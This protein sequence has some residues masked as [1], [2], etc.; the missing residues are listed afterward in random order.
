MSK[1]QIAVN[2]VL[3]VLVAISVLVISAYCYYELTDKTYT[4][5]TNYL[6][7]QAPIDLYEKEGLSD[8]Q[9][10]EYEKRKL[11]TV[12]Y[13]SN[14]ADNGIQLQ[15]LMFN[16]F[17]DYTLKESSVRS[18]GM[19][20][21]GDFET[22]YTQGQGDD[23]V[24]NDF[25]YYDKTLGISWS[26]YK[27]GY[28]SV[29]TVL[30]RNTKLTVRIDDEA[31]DIQLTGSFKYGGIFGILQSTGYYDYGDFFDCVLTAIESNSEGYGDYYITLDLTTF[32]TIYKFDENGKYVEDDVTDIINN[33]AV[34]SFHYD[35]N[36]AITANQSLFGAVECNTNWTYYEQVDTTYWQERIVYNLNE[37]QLDLRYSESKQG[38]YVSMN[39]TMKTF[40]KSMPRTKLIVTIDLDNLTTKDINLLGIDFNGFDGVRIDTLIIK[41]SGNFELL[42]NSLKDTKLQTLKHDETITLV[43]SN[44]YINNEYTEVILW[45]KC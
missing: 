40:Y 4:V 11:C 15:E 17:T 36:G 18:T 13:Y 33:Y 6:D 24:V 20:Y 30:N 37:S 5:G 32:F 21:I 29:A 10:A 26:G 41:G 27:A 34:I 38:F 19:Q 31:Y 16:Y 14:D 45:Y 9:I 2:I 39:S 43:K 44:D 3:I 1:L 7:S 23:K 22:Y 12:N 42:S 25:Y 8:E 35:E 28:G